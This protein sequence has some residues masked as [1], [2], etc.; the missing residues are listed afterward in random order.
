M[1]TTVEK[2]SVGTL[3]LLAAAPLLWAGGCDY[4]AGAKLPSDKPIGAF[5]RQLLETAFKAA[6]SIP[7]EPHIKDRS[8]AQQAVVEACLELDQPKLALSYVE[9]IE[10]W[11]GGLCFAELAVY[12]ADTGYKQQ[13]ARCLEPARRIAGN[14]QSQQWRNNRIKLKIAEARATLGQ[15]ALARELKAG[16]AASQT[17]PVARAEAMISDESPFDDQVAVLDSLLEE[18]LNNAGGLVL[19]AYCRLF[20]RFYEEDKRRSLVEER[21]R[22]SWGKVPV[23]FRLELL[24][25]LAGCALKHSDRRKAL[26]LVNEA[27]AVLDYSRWRVEQLVAHAATLSRLRFRAGDVHTAR[28]D[29]DTALALF[30]TRKGEILNIHRSGALRSVAEA[31]QSMGDAAA[32]LSVYKQALEEGIQNPNSRPCA[33][34]LSAVCRSMALCGA[35]PDGELW[36][37][38]H[39][40]KEGLGP[41]W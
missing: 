20:D 36:R 39:R 13:A 33:E 29:L 38:I 16:L 40:V 28:T 26:D 27:R 31:Y 32:A 10:N 7:V 25:D 22:A 3:L 8:R 11:R 5:R 4:K 35:E 34:D 1:N 9:R 18:P 19:R 15:A 23:F 17:D 2:S 12:C 21:I 6:S 14:D 30:N 41:P 37:L 24:L